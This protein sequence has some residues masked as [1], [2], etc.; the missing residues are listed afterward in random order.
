MEVEDARSPLRDVLI[1][2]L[3]FSNNR[4][5]WGLFY[6]ASGSSIAMLLILIGLS[7]WSV[8][9]GSEINGLVA[10]GQEILNDVEILL[11]N[12]AQALE[13]LKYMCRHENFTRTY[14]DD[15]CPDW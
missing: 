14:G 8:S 13:L 1:D 7:S 9:I 12:A 11:P 15:A 10:Q 6:A 4:G 2:T 3:S 5:R